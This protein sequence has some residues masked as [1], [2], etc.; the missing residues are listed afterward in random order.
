[1]R[2]ERGVLEV[3]DEEVVEL[4]VA[5]RGDGGRLHQEARE[6]DGSL[7]VEHLEIATVEGGEL[8]PAGESPVAGLRRDV[9]RLQERLLR[10]EEELPHLV[11]ESTEL[12]HRAVGRPLLTV[13]A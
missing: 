13:L 3:V 9:L 5:L 4:R 7:R 1:L 10:A 11:R 6:V 8:F 12:E 2:R